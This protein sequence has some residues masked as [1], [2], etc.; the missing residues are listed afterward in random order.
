M[1][2]QEADVYYYHFVGDTLRDGRPVPPDGEW[3]EHVGELIPCE[4]G[5]HASEHP[6]DAMRNAPGATLCLVELDGEIIPHGAPV[7]KVVAR[8]RRIVR[9]IDAT[10]L[11]RR[12][13]ADQALSVAHLWDMPPVVREYLTTLDESK[14]TEARSA[15]GSLEA[16]RDVSWS[17]RRSAAWEA[18]WSAMRSA[19]WEAAW[20]AMLDSLEAA[21][22]AAWSV[23][24]K[25]ARSVAWKAARDDFRERVNNQFRSP[26]RPV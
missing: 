4:A 16:A 15:A 10:H 22:A 7:D 1:N 12:F 14:R 5:L 24:W 3:L 8:R 13:A 21:M 26:P 20:K 23:A 11:L 6:F 25:A 17:A 9:R 19:A 2:H 18:A